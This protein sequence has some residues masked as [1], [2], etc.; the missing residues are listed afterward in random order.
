MSH[1][2]RGFLRDLTAASAAV[3]LSLRSGSAQALPQPQA[4]GI[5]HVIIVTME[6]RS[7]DHFLGWLPGADG[8]QA[9]LSYADRNGAVHAT[10][11]LGTDYTGCGHPDPTHAYNDSRTAYDAGQMDGFLRAGSNDIFAIGY[12]PE[13]TLPFYTALARGFLVCDRYF[14]SILGP[15]FPNRIFSW[16]AQ[17]DRLGDTVSLT[18]LPTIFDR[19][20]AANISHR[21]YFN[22]LPFLAFWGFKYLF[23]TG[24]FGEF[25]ASAAA[26]SLP[27][28]SFVDP[29][30]T[31]LDD[32]TGND[33]HPHADIRNGDAF[34]GRVFQAV[35]H[36]PSWKS[37]VLI[38][39]FDE[40]GGFF[41]HVAPPRAAAPNNVDTDL[42]NGQALLGFRVPTIIASPFTRNT[43][44]SPLVSHEVFDHTS[45]L[46]LI[47]W[48][49]GL[50][51]LT[52]RDASSQ[53]GN[54]ATAMN[55]N[56]PNTDVSGFPIPAA[57]TAAPCFGGTIFDAVAA[58][59]PEASGQADP[60]GGKRSPWLGLAETETVRQWLGHPRFRQR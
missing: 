52:A 46:K 15:T 59:P 44:A 57:V 29:N 53:I 14:V 19:L 1:T 55:F 27:A 40:W 18:S 25:L 7:F 54:P 10:Y 38:I 6:N 16:A 26:G 60:E 37:T 30:F 28:V 13:G 20:A 31:L 3:N 35:S 42:V 51:P 45:A 24:T 56:S 12:Y 9:G 49:W 23:S 58:R 50:Q 21:Y 8:K 43:G 2:R 4:S 32:G 48:R 39:T 22:N 36:G 34:L 5:E 41:D 17:T 47:E 11:S 33:D